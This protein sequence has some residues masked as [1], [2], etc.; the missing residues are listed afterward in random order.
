MAGSVGSLLQP[1]SPLTN[2]SEQRILQFVVRHLNNLYRYRRQFLG[3]SRGAVCV[4]LIE[5]ALA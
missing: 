5:Y 2:G 4:Y 1:D 3:I